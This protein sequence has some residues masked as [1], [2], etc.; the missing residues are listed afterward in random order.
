MVTEYWWHDHGQGRRSYKLKRIDCPEYCTRKAARSC[1]KG[2]KG[3]SPSQINPWTALSSPKPTNHLQRLHLHQFRPQFG[4]VTPS[5]QQRPYVRPISVIRQ[6]QIFPT[7]RSDY[8]M[9][10]IRVTNSDLNPASPH[11]F[12]LCTWFLET[13]KN[14]RNKN[15]LQIQPI[16]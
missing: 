16:K 14:F 8:N 10:S 7:Y 2:S 1:L 5:Q 15:I 3:T 13:T 6:P 11:W 12:L 9:V 4:L